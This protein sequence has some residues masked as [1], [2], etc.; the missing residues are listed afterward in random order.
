VFIALLTLTTATPV[1]D[2]GCT[3]QRPA[4]QVAT[5]VSK[6]DSLSTTVGAAKI[7]ICYSRPLVNGRTIFGSELVPWDKLWRTGANE[8]T[9]IHTTGM[10]QVAGIMLDAGSYSLYTV[11]H[12]NGEWDLVINRSIT[13]WGHESTYPSVESQELARAKVRATALPQSVEALTMTFSNGN[14]LIDWEKTRVAIPV[15]AGH[16]GH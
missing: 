8:P 16:A 3:P 2:P 6:Y 10:I 1:M 13:Q 14:L 5:R 12:A 9:I 7:T 11:P 15:T 4:D